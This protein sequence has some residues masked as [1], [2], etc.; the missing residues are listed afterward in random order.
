MVLY[1]RLNASQ[2]TDEEIHTLLNEQTPQ[3]SCDVMV[4]SASN[5]EDSKGTYE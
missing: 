5:T 2:Q 1:P 4:N 3:S